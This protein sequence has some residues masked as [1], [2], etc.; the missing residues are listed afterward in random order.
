VGA[1]RPS[2]TG[3][4]SGHRPAGQRADVLLTIVSR[5]L[6]QEWDAATYH[7]VSAPQVSWGS[8]VLGRLALVGDE[9]V[10]DAGCGTG[11]LTADL[12]ERLPRGRVIAVDQSTNTLAEAAAHL[13]TRF[14]DRISFL[15]ADVQH[16]ELSEPVDAIFSTATIHWVPDHPQLFR[17][18]YTC[19]KPGGRIV[20]QCGGPNLS[21]LRQRA[22][23]LLASPEFR[24]KAIGWKNPWEFATPEEAAWRL[25]AAGFTEIETSLEPAATTFPDAQAFSVFVQSVVL[26]A[27]LDALPSDVDR[28]AFMAE[29]TA[30]AAGDN[31]AFTLDYWRLNLVA[32]RPLAP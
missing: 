25:A 11:R 7:R 6:P 26:R 15:H 20:A 13:T 29:I 10:V 32:R 16:L 8:K 1:L 4:E 28:R 23:S 21:R 17:T 12:L 9:T 24:A 22:E 30:L 31:P 27:H 3:S 5:D 14:G 2:P 18:L 19:L